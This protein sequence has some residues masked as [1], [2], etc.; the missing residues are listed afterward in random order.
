MPLLRQIWEGGW[1]IWVNVKLSLPLFLSLSLSLASFLVGPSPCPLGLLESLGVLVAIIGLVLW[2]V[3]L[4]DPWALGGFGSGSVGLR[5]PFDRVVSG[6]PLWPANSGGPVGPLSLLARVSSFYRWSF[7]PLGSVSLCLC[8]PGRPLD[9]C[10][11]S[12][13]LFS[14]GPYWAPSAR[15]CLLSSF[16][17]FPHCWLAGLGGWSL[18][19]CEALGRRPFGRG[20]RSSWPFVYMLFSSHIAASISILLF[21]RQ[22]GSTD[23]IFS[24]TEVGHVLLV[25]YLC[26]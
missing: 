6:G 10:L 12:P 9:L 2:P 22:R 4:L 17:V 7:V 19:S 21:I 23:F 20:R 1:G 13:F 11:L 26:S 16:L 5:F 3:C 25:F 8:G 14:A 15:S 24:K 18:W